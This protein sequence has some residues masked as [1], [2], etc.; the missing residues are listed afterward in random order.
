V[1]DARGTGAG[2]SV[3]VT[4]TAPT[5]DGSAAAAGTGAALTLIPRAPVAE[6]GNPAVAG[7]PAM[8]P[9]LLGTI[10]A[11]IV[12]APAGTGRGRWN[13]PADSGATES[14]AILIPADAGAGAFSS[15]LTFTTAPPVG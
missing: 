15:T 3:T 10:A 12:N 11:T 6:A 13:V 8:A 1:G 14:L 4:A 5:V 2:Y 7:V 9:Q